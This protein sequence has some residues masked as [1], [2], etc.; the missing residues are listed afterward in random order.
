M[1]F[2]DTNNNGILDSGEDTNGNGYLDD[3][4]VNPNTAGRVMRA[5]P[6]HLFVPAGGLNGTSIRRYLTDAEATALIGGS[7]RGFPFHPMD[8]QYNTN[9]SGSGAVYT[10]GRMGPYSRIGATVGGDDP[11]EFDYDNDGDGYREAILMD[12]DFPAQQDASGNLFVPMYMI[13]IHDLDGL[14][15]LNAHGNLAKLLYGP[16]DVP[17][18]TIPLASDPTTPFGFSSGQ[19]TFISQSNLGVSPSEINPFMGPEWQAF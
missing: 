7:A 10:A 5:H 16:N 8:P 9:P 15:N 2:E 6:S 13:T 12:L 17:L 14:I 1:I 19:F 4:C 18:A 11:I 3:W